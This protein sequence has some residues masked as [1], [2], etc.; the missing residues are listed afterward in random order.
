[1]I[2][3]KSKDHLLQ[4]I[5]LY[6]YRVT[7]KAH[8][9]TACITVFYL[10]SFLISVIF[11]NVYKNKKQEMPSRQQKS[12]KIGPERCLMFGPKRILVILRWDD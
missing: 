9:S 2:F 6:N 1:M 4:Y 11:I 3:F 8:K 5:E 7:E 12:A 10:Y